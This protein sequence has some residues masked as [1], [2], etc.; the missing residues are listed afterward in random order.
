MIRLFFIFTSFCIGL[1]AEE[2][3]FSVDGVAQGVRNAHPSGF[4][5]RGAIVTLTECS[6]LPKEQTNQLLK[7]LIKSGYKDSNNLKDD[8][9]I[10]L[11][12]EEDLLKIRSGW[13]IK[14]SG[15]TEPTMEGG[16]IKRAGTFDRIQYATRPF[17][18]YSWRGLTIL[19]HDQKVED[20]ITSRPPSA[21]EVL[22]IPELVELSDAFLRNGFGDDFK[23]PFYTFSLRSYPDLHG[24]N[25]WQANVTYSIPKNMQD[26]IGSEV[27]TIRMTSRGQILMRIVKSELSRIPK[28]E[29]V[30]QGGADQPATAPEL[31]SEGKDKPQPESKVRPQ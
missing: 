16:K 6:G 26:S 24:N 5:F 12:P 9:A 28:F 18:L 22:S 21:G 30:E 4:G 25:F 2:S 19:E 17:P 23:L 27:L 20:K 31:K 29:E 15:Y 10:I 3:S 13:S 11:I 14:V 7:A 8:E 1:Y